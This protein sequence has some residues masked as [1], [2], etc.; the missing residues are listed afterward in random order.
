MPVLY[1]LH[2]SGV[3]INRRVTTLLYLRKNMTKEEI[4]KCIIR[5][6]KELIKFLL[7]KNKKLSRE[8][9]HEVNNK[10][11]TIQLYEEVLEEYEK[12]GVSNAKK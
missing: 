12:E 2:K 11:N 1:L 6:Q 10:R 8:A 4:L 7:D 3:N 5:N 9:S